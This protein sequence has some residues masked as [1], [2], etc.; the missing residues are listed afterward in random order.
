MIGI[1][2]RRN[3]R[4]MIGR[5][6]SSSVSNVSSSMSSSSSA[7]ATKSSRS[8][9]PT[10]AGV[11]LMSPSSKL[12]RLP[13]PL[14]AIEPVFG[15][16]DQVGRPKFNKNFF[17]NLSG[18]AAVELDLGFVMPAVEDEDGRSPASMHS[19]RSAVFAPT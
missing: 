14:L 17:A 9:K 8:T 6:I 3:S 12:L 18:T 7:P 10:P 5:A 15:C 2:K 4:G 19:V 16:V 11:D 1:K 13:L